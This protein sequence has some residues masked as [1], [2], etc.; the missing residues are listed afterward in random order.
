MDSLR[1]NP[2]SCGD[3]DYERSY[4]LL[5]QE[6]RE[7]CFNDVSAKICQ[8]ALALS[9]ANPCVGFFAT[10]IKR[11]FSGDFG[12]PFNVPALDPKDIFAQIAYICMKAEIGIYL[13]VWREKVAVLQIC[14][15]VEKIDEIVAIRLKYMKERIERRMDNLHTP[16]VPLFAE[17]LTSNERFLHYHEGDRTYSLTIGSQGSKTVRNWCHATLRG[18]VLNIAADSSVYVKEDSDQGSGCGVLILLPREAYCFDRQ[19]NLL[20]IKTEKNHH[21]STN[22]GSEKLIDCWRLNGYEQIESSVG[23]FTTFQHRDNSQATF[24]SQIDNDAILGVVP[25]NNSDMQ[26]FIR[27]RPLDQTIHIGKLKNSQPHGKV[28]CF[29][30]RM[31]SESWWWEGNLLWVEPVAFSYE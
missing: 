26:N 11:V 20:T 6:C 10:E 30:P 19:N 23:G 29:A 14:Q 13:S 21:Y 4:A 9:T 5:K 7:L 8:S 27:F 1:S 17:T 31:A 16:S 22:K 15:M 18:I 12:L 24:I 25:N 2:Y 3:V 28:I